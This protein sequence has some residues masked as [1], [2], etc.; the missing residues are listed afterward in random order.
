MKGM[1]ISSL[2]LFLFIFVFLFPVLL[3]AGCGPSSIQPGMVNPEMDPTPAAM[4]LQPTKTETKDAF[5]RSK[6]GEIE[7]NITYCSPKNIPQKLDVYYPSDLPRTPWPVVVYVHGGA[8]QSGDKEN[9]LYMPVLSD[10]RKTGFLIVS[11]NYRLAPRY[12]FPAQIED[13][14]CAIRFLRAQAKKYNIEPEKIG[15]L[16]DSAGGHIVALLGLADSYTAWDTTDFS[17]QSNQVQ[18]VVDLYGVSDLTRVFDRDATQVWPGVFNANKKSDPQLI[19][20]SP[21]TYV[22]PEAPP[23]LIIHG[24]QDRV[25][26]FQ[27]SQSLFDTLHAAGN[28]VDFITVKNADHG[29]NPA[30]S[31]P[32]DPDQ[33]EI[34]RRITVFFSEQLK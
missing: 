11:I 13:A 15:V 1:R 21:L 29:F 12:P 32:I 14:R 20:A 28:S 2:F 6:L 19:I 23:F 33:N 24:D 31:L 17:D 26:P 16:G 34:N 30:G 4:N 18:A 22:H 8:W 5:D 7:S 25:V 10:L 3:F 27:Q 9:A